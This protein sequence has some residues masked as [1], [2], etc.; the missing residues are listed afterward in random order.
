VCVKSFFFFLSF[1]FLQKDD[2]FFLL[3]IPKNPKTI[4]ASSF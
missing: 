1:I 2:F 4:K 3:Q